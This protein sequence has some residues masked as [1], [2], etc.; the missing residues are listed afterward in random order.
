M[1]IRHTFTLAI[2]IGLL[3][4]GCA[5]ASDEG[6]ANEAHIDRLMRHRD[7]PRI[8]QIAK[9]EVR[10]REI[11]WPDDASYLPV[12]HK[13]KIWAVTGM[14]ATPKREL[15]RV[16]MLTIGDDGS[17][18]TYKRYWQGKEVPGW[19]DLHSK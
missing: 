3:L 6:R 5:T 9:D 14:T 15:Q 8:Q 4:S 11:G 7:W 19:D 10:K 2:S 1:N 16:V 17:V 12:E 18:S 13:D